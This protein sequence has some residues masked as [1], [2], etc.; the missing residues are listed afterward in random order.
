MINSSQFHFSSFPYR[1][2]QRGLVAL[3]LASVFV[4]VMLG[5]GALLLVLR[6]VEALWSPMYVLVGA[7][8]V[9]D[10]LSTL[11]IIPN[12]LLALLNPAYSVSLAECLTQMFLTYF[13]SSLES[14][15]L[16]AMALDRYVAICRPLRYR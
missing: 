11:V 5:N 9:V 3:P 1:P 2:W 16:L 6:R 14:T 12:A 10:M 8:C 7:L 4:L 15:L 13:L